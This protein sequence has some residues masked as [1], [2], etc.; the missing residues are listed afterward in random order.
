[1]DT[2]KCP[3]LA[4]RRISNTDHEMITK[5]G[6][7]QFPSLILIILSNGEWKELSP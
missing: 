1:M 3:T 5:Y 2:S 7:M 6:V 4:V